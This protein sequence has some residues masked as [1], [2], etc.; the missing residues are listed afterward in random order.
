MGRA[1]GGG[2]GR[3]PSLCGI[4]NQHTKIPLTFSFSVDYLLQRKRKREIK[5]SRYYNFGYIYIIF[6]SGDHYCYHY[7]HYYYCYV[8]NGDDKPS[9]MYLLRAGNPLAVC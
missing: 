5:K 8:S 4:R 6:Y 3:K 7:Y 2:G 1:V 9:V